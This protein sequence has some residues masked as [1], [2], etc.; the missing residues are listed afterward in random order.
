MITILLIKKIVSLFLIM[1]LGALTVRFNVV[2]SSD[3]RIIS[4]INLYLINPC[5]ILNAYQVDVT[6]NTVKGLLLAF[7]A[8]VLYHLVIISVMSPVSKI[9]SLERVEHVSI[10]YGNSGVLTIPL[11]AAI[12][13][14]EYVIYTSAFICVQTFLFWTHT[15]AVLSGDSSFEL[16][17]I[18]TNVNM[19]A[20]LAGIILFFSGIRFSGPVKDS[21]ESLASMVGP[22]GMLIIGMVMAGVDLKTVLGYKK[23]WIVTAARLIIVPLI[24]LLS[25]KYLPIEGI[26]ENA[27]TVLLISLLGICGP[28]ASMIVQMSQ[29]YG[30]DEKYASAV[31]VVTTLLCIITIP[32]MVMLYQI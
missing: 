6:G 18:A 26:V 29:I 30:G 32:V 8:A 20:I 24:T 15:K 27:K 22:V 3:S 17:K 19:I 14:S 28:S 25:F 23:I 2:K 21:V 10:I 5:V 12:L 31:N 1:I 13:G 7:V 9:F 11:V 4:L 16:K